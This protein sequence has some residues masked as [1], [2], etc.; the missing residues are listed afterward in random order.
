MTLK[1]LP[2]FVVIFVLSSPIFVNAQNLPP[3]LLLT[4]EEIGKR[5]KDDPYFGIM[6]AEDADISGKSETH[7][8]PFQTSGSTPKNIK[9]DSQF[10]KT[11]ISSES[12]KKAF[13]KR[14]KEMSDNF[15]GNKNK[16]SEKYTKQVS[17]LKKKYKERYDFWKRYVERYRKDVA[18][19]KKNLLNPQ[20]F[21]DEERLE[22]EARQREIERKIKEVKR[23]KQEVVERERKR[24]KAERI[25]VEKEERKLLRIKLEK[26][27]QKR[28]ERERIMNDEK[29]KKEERR[30]EK[31]R[32][33]EE[34]RK[35]KIRAEERKKEELRILQN[36]ERKLKEELRLLEKEE[37][38]KEVERKRVA[39]K[40]RE[41]PPTPKWKWKVVDNSL[42]LKVKS[43]SSRPTCSSFAS[44]RAI[45]IKLAQS[46]KN[47][48]LSE[49]YFYWA[50]K[51][52]CQRLPCKDW[53]SSFGIGI[54]ASKLSSINDIPAESSC[55]Y[56]NE[57]QPN[58]QT[59]IP[60][61]NGCHQDGIA[62]VVEYEY[63][64]SVDELPSF[65][66]Q[67]HPVI[68]GFTLS[69]GYYKTKAFL[70][71]AD[72]NKLGATDS[73]KGGHAFNIIGYME[74]PKSL[75]RD[76]GKRC[77]IAANSWGY[78]WGA[79]GHSCISEAWLKKHS[80]GAFFAIKAV[81]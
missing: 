44:I 80:R 77:Y 18:S 12:M 14:K 15:D 54:Q 52:K 1:I 40:R 29:Q 51:P 74:L 50:S 39:E 61:K 64:K 48:D 63:F 8:S 37:R 31:K 26:E 43:Q 59:Q 27:R 25:R 30:L 35:L 36:E 10:I 49:Q 28:Q 69:A 19:Y 60:L 68:G 47:I 57:D 17:K 71:V 23:K 5:V 3:L 76:E 7:G 75:H 79:G 65:L 13:Q 42:N 58:N 2:I 53:G 46:G 9:T 11:D 4:I 55:P 33:I 67:N 81:K 72:D 56:Q 73:N 6:L 78:G 45:E 34:E 32:K 16:M 22:E 62:K 20:E 38:R 21:A 24:R 41:I 66:D 70:S